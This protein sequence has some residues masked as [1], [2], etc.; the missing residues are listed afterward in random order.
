MGRAEQGIFYLLGKSRMSHDCLTTVN[1]ET[2]E[3]SARKKKWDRGLRAAPCDVLGG[4]VARSGHRRKTRPTGVCRTF[5][6]QFSLRW[7][8][9]AWGSVVADDA[10]ED[11][12]TRKLK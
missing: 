7:R 11:R 4:C 10:N 5:L 8:P 6:R 9:C 2:C 12:A 3:L 1:E